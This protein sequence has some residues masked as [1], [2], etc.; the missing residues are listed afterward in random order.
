MPAG[1]IAYRRERMGIHEETEESLHEIYQASLSLLYK[2]LFLLY[3]EARGLLPVDNAGY[4]EQSLTALAQWAADRRDRDVPLSTATHAT[5]KYDALLALFHRIDQGDPS[6]GIPRYNGGLF[7]P[8][9]ADN[10]FLEQHRLS[11]RAVACAVDILVR[12]A[13][14]PVDYA[15][16]SV[17]NLGAIYEG[18]LENKLRITNSE[19]RESS[20]VIHNSQFVI[21]LVNDKGERKAT[22]SYYTPDYIVEYIVQQTLEPI[23]EARA[24][25]FAA[26]MARVADMRRALARTA[27]PGKVRLLRRQLD[28]AERDAR[29]AFLGIK[30]L[31]P[32]MGV[33]PFPGERRGLSHRRHHPTDADLPRRPPRHFLGLEPHPAVGGARASRNPG[34]DGAP[35]HRARPGAARRYRA[36]HP[37]G[38][39]ALHLRRGPEQDGGG[40]GEVEPVAALLHRGRAAELPGSPPALGQQ[41]HR[42]GRADGGGG[43]SGRTETPGSSA[44]SPG[45]SPGCWT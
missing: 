38:D 11:D 7:N 40:T 12:D 29:E 35:E 27:D 36:A 22:G 24:E 4:R 34:G 21:Q 1:F 39:E 31:D 45:R 42:D 23:L 41:P 15:Y 33:G 20:S 16:I 9:N 14:Q 26:G 2:L 28:A 19:L 30:V 6:L 43:D 8:E 3:A 18:L 44:C 32:A 5:S 25:T 17:R 13:G 10:A 37:P